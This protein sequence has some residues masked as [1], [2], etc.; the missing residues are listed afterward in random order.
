MYI[1][2]TDTHIYSPKMQR[3]AVVIIPCL[4]PLKVSVQIL[5]MAKCT[6]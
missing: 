1:T 2:T 6:R 4:S 5:L 3:A